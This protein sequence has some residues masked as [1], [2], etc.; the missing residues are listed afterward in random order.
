MFR[1]V[2]SLADAQIFASPDRNGPNARLAR[3]PF[4]PAYED[5]EWAGDDGLARNCFKTLPAG[6]RSRYLPNLHMPEQAELQFPRYFACNERSFILT[7]L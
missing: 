1:A 3:R 4:T 5:L 6:P 7:P 2:S